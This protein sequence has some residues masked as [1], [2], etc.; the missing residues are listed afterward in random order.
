[1][2]EIFNKFVVLCNGCGNAMRYMGEWP[3]VYPKFSNEEQEN[4]KHDNTHQALRWTCKT[5]RTPHPTYEH[6]IPVMVNLLPDPE[7]LKRNGF[8]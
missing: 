1:M 3:I 2:Y 5:C 6:G 8:G 7:F 4:F